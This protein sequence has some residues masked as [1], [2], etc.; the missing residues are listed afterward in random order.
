M[1]PP[2]LAGVVAALR[3]TDSRWP[4]VHPTADEEDVAEVLAAMDHEHAPTA[5]EQEPDGSW[6][7]CIG[8]RKPWPCPDWQWAQHLAVQYLGRAA[9]RYIARR[10]HR[11]AQ[12]KESA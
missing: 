9:D 10:A 1:T 7:A 5:D 2:N 12:Q 3:L 6:G 11:V 8:C 4:W